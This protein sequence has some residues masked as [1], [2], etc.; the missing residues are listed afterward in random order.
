MIVPFAVI[1]TSFFDSPP[2]WGIPALTASATLVGALI[3]FWS[4]RASDKRKHKRDTEERIMMD[5]RAVGI[6]YLDAADSLS[7][8]I[9]AQS[10]PSREKAATQFLQAMAI[11]LIDM[12][13]VRGKFELFAH[14]D[15]LAAAKDLDVASVMLV[16]DISTG[17]NPEKDLESFESAKLRLVNILRKFSGV[18]EIDVDSVSEENKFKLQK[19][20]VSILDYLEEGMAKRFANNQNEE[21]RPK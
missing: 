7:R 10:D 6:E 5:T 19:D 14:Q 16:I 15:A 2:W 21:E 8:L 4:A 9:R 17:V 3:A 18:E 11:A 20:M 12:Q 1:S 13:K